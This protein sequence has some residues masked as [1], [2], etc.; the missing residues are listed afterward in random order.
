MFAVR[1]SIHAP[2]KGATT[3][4]NDDS[5]RVDVS[6]HAPVKG[7]TPSMR[8]DGM[9]YE[10]SIHAPVKGATLA[11]HGMSTGQHGFDPRSREGSDCGGCGPII[12]NMC[13]D[14]R[15]REGKRSAKA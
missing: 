14:P 10:V 13:F 12:H 7:A 8:S 11:P 6:I 2:V 4:L 1:V 15:S 5:N 9:V 3:R